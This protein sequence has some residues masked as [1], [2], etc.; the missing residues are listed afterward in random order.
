MP[1][2]CKNREV[3]VF[4]SLCYIAS[5][6]NKGLLEQL[7]TLLKT[8]F[9]IETTLE[10]GRLDIT[11]KKSIQTFIEQIGVRYC[12]HKAHSLTAVLSY[13]KYTD[14]IES[15]PI[16][17]L[18]DYLKETGLDV[19]SY[20]VDKITLPCYKLKVISIEDA[21]EHEV[22]DL[23]IEE[24]YSNYVSA[25][26]IS[27]N[28]NEPPRVPGQDEATWNRIRILEYESKFVLP[29]DMN[30]WPVPTD[31]EDQFKLKRFKADGS[32]SKRLP[33]LAPVFLWM[34]FE[35]YKDYKKRG[36]REPQEVSMATNVYR[37]MNDIFMQFIED[38]IEPVPFD[39]E[40]KKKPFL[41]LSDLHAEFTT[42]YSI[43]HSSYAK[44]KITKVTLLHEFNKRLGPAVKQTKA[45]QGWY[46]YRIVE[47]EGPTDEKQQQLQNILNGSKKIVA[48][49]IKTK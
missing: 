11:E 29:H 48:A 26:A 13:Y 41:K 8:R 33:D 31:E 21:G 12:F 9:D 18:E 42:W 10:D 36:L 17:Q 30:K 27:H 32:F 45:V 47:D 40:D 7:S 22:F 23:T 2:V 5:K 14:L 1:L 49:P 4:S 43:N 15:R 3:S 35:R 24:P 25:G 37:A 20:A 44:E 38:M 39:P 34:L 16:M 6:T 28:C 46:G 19:F